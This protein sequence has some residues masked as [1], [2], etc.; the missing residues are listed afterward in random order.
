MRNDEGQRKGSKW[1]KTFKCIK[2]LN[3]LYM[4]S[5]CINKY[6]MQNNRAFHDECVSCFQEMRTS[7]AQTCFFFFDA[8]IFR[9]FF[10]E[11]SNFVCACV[12]ARACVCMCVLIKFQSLIIRTYE[13]NTFVSALIKKRKRE[14]KKITCTNKMLLFMDIYF[15]KEIVKRSNSLCKLLC[16]ITQAYRNQTYKWLIRRKIRR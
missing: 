13:Y 4:I 7:W 8:T 1:C 15:S 9:C 11:L 5:M 3:R 6:T 14:K 16:D 12:R 2:R 10:I